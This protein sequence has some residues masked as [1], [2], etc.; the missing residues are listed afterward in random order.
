MLGVW[1]EWWLERRTGWPSSIK[2]L[3]APSYFL[4]WVLGNSEKGRPGLVRSA[5]EKAS[6]LTMSRHRT[7]V[8][9]Y[10]DIF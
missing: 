5:R 7:V 4:S 6:A 1:S 3:E 9:P 8:A 10:Y 2:G